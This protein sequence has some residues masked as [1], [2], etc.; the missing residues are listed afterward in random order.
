MRNLL[1]LLGLGAALLIG[2]EATAAEPGTPSVNSKRQVIT[3]MVK[4]MSSNRTLSYNDAMKACKEQLDARDSSAIRK[5]AFAAN[6]PAEP[7]A[8]KT[9]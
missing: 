7:P 6:A 2:T 3:C 5:G 4:S 1:G 9:P 8:V